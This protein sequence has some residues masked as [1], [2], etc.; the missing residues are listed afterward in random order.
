MENTFCVELGSFARSMVKEDVALS[1]FF[2]VLEKLMETDLIVC[3]MHHFF[4]YNTPVICSSTII[5][6]L[7]VHMI[8][9]VIPYIC[10][11]L[12]LRYDQSR[13]QV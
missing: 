5:F 10:W 3:V 11:R 13:K 7:I 2:V 8:A 4:Y 9:I 1:L 6:C 12:S